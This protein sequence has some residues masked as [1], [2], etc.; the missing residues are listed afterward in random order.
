MPATDARDALQAVCEAVESGEP[1]AFCPAH[2]HLAR[3]VAVQLDPA[4]IRA[5]AG[6]ESS[7]HSTTNTRW[8]CFSMT[9]CR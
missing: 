6:I 8:L 9:S 1:G 5:R 2:A 3:H 7:S 4:A